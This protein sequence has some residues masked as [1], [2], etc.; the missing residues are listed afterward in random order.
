MSGAAP[1]DILLSHW[2]ATT[3]TSARTTVPIP[4]GQQPISAPATLVEDVA[5]WPRPRKVTVC[6]GEPEVF[7]G[8][9]GREALEAFVERMRER[10]GEML[11]GGS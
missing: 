4:R 11:E 8:G 5:V 9:R 10:V 7:S 2:N 3:Q 1:C 6:F